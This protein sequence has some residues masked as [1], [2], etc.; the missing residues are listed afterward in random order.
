M[1]RILNEAGPLMAQYHCL[2]W[3]LLLFHYSGESLVPQL[4]PIEC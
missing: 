1:Q 4:F 3:Q 2:E